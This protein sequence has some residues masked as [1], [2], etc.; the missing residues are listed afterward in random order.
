MI[1][2]RTWMTSTNRQAVIIHRISYEQTTLTYNE[3]CGQIV[4]RVVSRCGQSPS[5]KFMML[6]TERHAYEW[7][8]RYG[9]LYDKYGNREECRWC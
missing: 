1:L 4:L 9:E 6:L 7:L 3:R 8:R 2:D 5:P